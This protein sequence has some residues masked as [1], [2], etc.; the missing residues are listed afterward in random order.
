VFSGGNTRFAILPP[1]A[2]KSAMKPAPDV[3]AK[4]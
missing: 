3:H 1:L 4:L 2:Q